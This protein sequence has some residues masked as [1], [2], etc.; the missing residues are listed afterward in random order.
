MKTQTVLALAFLAVG[1]QAQ[2]SMTTSAYGQ[3]F[4]T[5][6][7]AG[8]SLPWVNNAMPGLTGWYSSLTTISADNGTMNADGRYSLGATGSGERALGS[9]ALPGAIHFYGARLNNASTSTFT[10]LWVNY[11]GEQWRSSTSLADVLSFDYSTNAASLTTGTWTGVT[12]LNFNA[13]NF[14]ATGAIDGNLTANRINLSSTL[15][16]L[17]WTSGTDMWIRWT[18]IGNVSEQTLG[19]DNM[20]LQS[21]PVP[22]PFTMGLALAGLGMAARKRMRKESA[23]LG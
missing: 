7:I 3:N 21:N 17:N 14:S 2:V 6:P 11:F 1:A 5:L 20:R 15:T 10:S 8:T 18:H 22:E 23:P 13:L 16:G 12:A 9:H 4:D 19:I